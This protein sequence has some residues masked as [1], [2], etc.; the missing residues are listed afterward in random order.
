MIEW[1]AV[2]QLIESIKEEWRSTEKETHK[3]WIVKEKKQ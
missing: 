2:N 3:D 1:Q